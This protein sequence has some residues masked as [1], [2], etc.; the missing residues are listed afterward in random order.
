MNIVAQPA[1]LLAGGI[2]HL[3]FQC[4]LC[5]N[6][7]ND[8]DI[9]V[10]L[11]NGIGFDVNRKCCAVLADR[12]L[13]LTNEVTKG[14]PTVGSRNHRLAA[15]EGTIEEILFTNQLTRRKSKDFFRGLVN[16]CHHTLVVD[17]DDCV[18]DCV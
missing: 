1:L 18:R 17:R 7:S 10:T 2:D 5:G 16:A 4:A 3:L 9:E 11:G 8:R 6:V 12:L 14:L 13:F 15:N